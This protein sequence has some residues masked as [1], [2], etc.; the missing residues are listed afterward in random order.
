MNSFLPLL[1]KH[2]LWLVA[3]LGAAYPLVFLLWD[4]WTDQLGINP[5][6][7]ITTRTGKAA[8]ILLLLSLACTP[9]N[10]LLSWPKVLNLRK[11]LGLWAFGYVSLHL[12]NFV[13]LDY[14][15][16]L[17]L[18]LGDT[19][20]TKRYIIVGFS[21]F[22][23]LLP[24]ALTSTKGWMKRLGRNWK[25]LHRLVYVAGGLAALHFIWLVKAA[26]L[27][28]PLIYAGVLAVLL[29]FR[30]PPVRKFIS[31]LRPTA[32]ARTAARPEAPKRVMSVQG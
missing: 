27:N 20:I 10:M 18:I 19:L 14:G 1:K 31:K 3:N 12:L 11:S 28:E 25:R 13:G 2:W 4:F 24:L 30:L 15:F 7:D 6:A 17:R 21:A 5:I 9:V 26:R 29:I 16:D 22:L 32:K 23:L 8:L